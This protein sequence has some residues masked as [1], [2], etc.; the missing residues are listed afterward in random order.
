MGKREERGERIELAKCTLSS[1]L[2]V[3][4]LMVLLGLV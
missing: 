3:K 2:N 4:L 1:G